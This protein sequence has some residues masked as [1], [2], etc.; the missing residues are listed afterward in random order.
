MQRIATCQSR[1]RAPRWLRAICTVLLTTAPAALTRNAI[2]QVRPIRGGNALDANPMAGSGGYNAARPTSTGINGNLIVSGNV[3]AGKAFRGYSPIANPNTLLTNIPS[4]AIGNFVRDSAGLPSISAGLNSP[5]AQPFFYPTDTAVSTGTVTNQA[6]LPRQVTG[7]VSVSQY[8]GQ[9]SV[10]PLLATLTPGQIVPQLPYAAA[11]WQPVGTGLFRPD[12]TN[13]FAAPR[14]SAGTVSADD[15]DA[16]F[17]P[18]ARRA[19]A[20]RAQDPG[21]QGHPAAGGA[22]DAADHAGA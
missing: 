9:M 14:Q 17:R 3:T 1:R 4:A 6:L 20:R 8:Q 2:A 7:T 12:I 5:T 11:A 15:A 13:S 22:A 10:S 18:Q 19:A 16:G 21:C